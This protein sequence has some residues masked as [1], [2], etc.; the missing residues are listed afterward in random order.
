MRFHADIIRENDARSITSSPKI[1][2]K[3]VLV[4]N[5]LDCI[6]NQP[7]KMKESAKSK[8]VGDI[9]KAKAASGAKKVITPVPA[10]AKAKVKPAA[11]ATK[12]T[13]AKDLVPK[14]VTRVSRAKLGKETPK[15]PAEVSQQGWSQSDLEQA[16]FLKWCHRRN[17]GLPDDPM[18]D[19]IAAESELGLAN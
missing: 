10:E 19:W 4:R 13:P 15:L 11:K 17:E 2:A 6:R 9:S 1:W 16:A 18:A 3:S 5:L 7:T 14:K 12:P 8:K